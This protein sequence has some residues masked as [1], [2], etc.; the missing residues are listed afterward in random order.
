ME[1]IRLRRATLFVIALALAL[2]G[3]AS[4]K[5]SR[6]NV[7]IFLAD[8]LGWADVGFRDSPIDTPT[9]DR[10]AAEGMQ[11]DRFYST[12]ICSPTR[13]ALMTGR[14]P[15]RLG[16]VYAVILPWSNAGIHPTERLM[17][18]AFRD[19]GYQT[20]MVGKW[21]LGHAQQTY[22]PNERGFEH[23]YGHLHTEV[24]YFPPFGNQ[25]GK[26][27]QQNG[28][29]IE[30]D[31]YETFLL[32]DEASRWI[33][34]RDEEKPFF[35]Y[36]PFIA[37][38]TPLDAP[39]ELKDKY[40]DLDDDR[41]PAR[42]GMTDRT[43]RIAKLLGR[44]SA[45][46]MFAA[47]VEAMDQAIGRV[48][49]TLDSEGLAED[50]IVL[51]FSDNGGAAYAMGGADNAPLR[52]GKGETFEGGIRVVSLMRWTGTI[53]GGEKMDSI[54]SVMDVF[55]TLADAAGVETGPT[56]KLDGRSLWPAIAEGKRIPRDDYLFFA[57]ET[58]IRGSIM[59]TAF[60]D[61]WKLVQ[62]V[63]QGQLSAE[64]TNHL[65]RIADDPNEYNNL[66]AAHPD[67]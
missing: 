26:D 48:L 38:H 18:E 33:R 51:F 40:A 9:L 64:V 50:T 44:E 7:V 27:F 49:A 1:A 62:D 47:V 35:L 46:P 2:P 24:G 5:P 39:Q 43:R 52:G 13:A 54:M 65:F 36:V 32:A 57:S 8:D 37:P 10:L 56:R 55:P 16:I 59:L 21:H 12:P 45:R 31:G 28:K 58:P 3:L 19:A 34:E 23:F 17:P 30:A 6:P 60:D 22:H 20:A 66:A 63:Q 41:A 4:A 29:S 14:D 67:V 11:L 15:I 42:S 25:G 61:E 53:D